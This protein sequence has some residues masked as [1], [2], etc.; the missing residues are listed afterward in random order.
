M[1]PNIQKIREEANW[2]VKDAQKIADELHGE[3]KSLVKIK[4]KVRK[5]TYRC[6]HLWDELNKREK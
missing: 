5:L 1:R 4:D 6:T 3:N 2:L